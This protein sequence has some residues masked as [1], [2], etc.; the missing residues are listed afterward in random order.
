MGGGEGHLTR[1]YARGRPL[2]VYP[3]RYVTDDEYAFRSGQCGGPGACILSHPTSPGCRAWGGRRQRGRCH[4]GG[5]E[6]HLTRYYARRSPSPWTAQII[7]DEMTS[8]VPCIAQPGAHHRETTG[9][10]LD[11]HPVPHRVGAEHGVGQQ[12]A[13]CHVGGLEGRLARLLCSGRPS[14]VPKCM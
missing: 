4:V 12:R 8:R 1:C 7:C 6:G 5:L 3:P 14:R 13:R 10:C 11:G 2:S 9:A